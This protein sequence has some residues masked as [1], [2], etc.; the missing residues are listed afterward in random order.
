MTEQQLS[1]FEAVSGSA[2][3]ADLWR[4]EV[5]DRLAGY[6]RRRG[7]RIEGAYTMRFPFPVDEVAEPAIPTE[8]AKAVADPVDALSEESPHAK[9]TLDDPRV[10]EPSESVVAGDSVAGPAASAPEA[11]IEDV[12][13]VL[14]SLPMQEAEPAAY[15]DTIPRPRPKRK[16]I[17][18]P[19]QLSVAPETAYRLADPVT[20]EV[21]RIL[22][23]P[24]EL[25]ST[26]FLDG[27][28]LDLPKSQQ[29]ESDREHVELPFR[30]VRI[31]QR[32]LAGIVDLA[33]IGCGFAVFAAVA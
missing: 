26:P 33:V 16:V 10:Q 5:Q 6:K 21:P 15:I 32:A 14:E 17:A 1:H 28:Q 22:D 25:E 20:A 31:S 9:A 11:M 30:S 27:L 23:V 4:N 2:Q 13:L 12:D 3:P 29:V 7:R 19:R 24:E 18:F 8:A